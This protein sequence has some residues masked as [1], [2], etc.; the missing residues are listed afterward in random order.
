M[1]RSKFFYLCLFS[2]IL[3]IGLTSCRNHQNKVRKEF[4]RLM[5]D[6][7]SQYTQ[8]NIPALELSYLKNIQ[9]ISSLDS[10][11]IQTQVFQSFQK[12]LKEITVDD[13]DVNHRSDY[14]T[15]SLELRLHLERLELEK[16]FQEKK[17]NRPL[18]KNGLYFIP[19][20]KKWYRYFVKRWTG[21]EITPEDLKTF[22]LAEI[23]KIKTEILKIQENLNFGND[24]I[25]FYEALNKKRFLIKDSSDVVSKFREQQ[26]I[27]R[28][29]IWKQFSPWNLSKEKIDQGKRKELSQVPGYYNRE[30]ET[31]YFNLFDD[32]F[33]LRQVDW[34][35][36]H[37]G[38]PGHHF[39]LSL[40]KQL[41]DS[42]PAY[43]DFIPFSGYREGWAA[44]AEEIGSEVGLYRTPYDWMGKHEWDLIRSVRVVLDVALNYQG[45][46]DE[47]ALTFWKQHIYNQDDI[48]EREIARMKR[49][50]GQVHTYKHG[51]D[52]ILQLKDIFQ[53]EEGNDF[54]IRKFHD[55]IL[56][57]GPLHWKALRERVL[58]DS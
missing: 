37:E 47:K 17:R 53:K 23:E 36:L 18:D 49:W 28:K 1:N 30:E 39:Q 20:G 8:L 34:L 2:Q 21:A 38:V 42:L 32:P 48:A 25:G 33:N 57:Y 50:P 19:N 43:R 52:Q 44:Y 45:W 3:L 26:T 7:A 13:L 55:R 16:E 6:F 10:I 22:G 29:E 12:R 11:A 41:T 5:D 46:S 31:F 35:Y 40:E 24:R 4:E 27:V 58:E 51:A 56:N 54:D 14:Q 9:N 15:I